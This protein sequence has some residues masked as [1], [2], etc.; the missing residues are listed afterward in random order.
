[1]EVILRLESTDL[2]VWP[3]TFGNLVYVA[4]SFARIKTKMYLSSSAYPGPVCRGSKLSRDTQT[5]LSLD[6][7][8]SSS[9]GSLRRS[10]ASRD[11]VPPAGPG[12]PP[13]W[14]VP[15]TPPEVSRRHPEQM[16]EEQAYL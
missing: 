6:T 5:S 16:P 7:S 11:I 13:R 2:I 8:S 1:M 12:P 9:G 3:N 10:Q 15:R 4:I 14:D